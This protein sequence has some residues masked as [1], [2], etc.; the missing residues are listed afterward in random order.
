MMVRRRH[1]EWWRFVRTEIHFD[2]G[3][4]QIFLPRSATAVRRR[5]TVLFHN[6]VFLH[7]RSDGLNWREQRWR[8]LKEEQNFQGVRKIIRTSFFSCMP[9]INSAGRFR[10]FRLACGRTT[11]FCRCVTYMCAVNIELVA[12]GLEHS[13]QK[14]GI[15]DGVGSGAVGTD[16]GRVTAG[17]TDN[18]DV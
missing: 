12:N 8:V 1:A 9:C 6:H 18:G 11:L 17:D 5:C 10:L 4:F 3:F 13:T 14:Q 16:E 7:I 15:G 2:S